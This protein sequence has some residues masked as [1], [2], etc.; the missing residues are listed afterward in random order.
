[1][2]VESSPPPAPAS[3]SG[4]SC[5]LIGCVGLGVATLVACLVFAALLRA[6]GGE[7]L[8]TLINDL[9][10]G[11]APGLPPLTD[12]DTIYADDFTD[13]K[14]G[15]R[16]F[17]GREGSARVGSGRLDLTVVGPEQDV[18][19]T[20]RG[21]YDDFRAEI[22]GGLLAGADDTSYGIIFRYQNDD[23]YYQFDVDG[24][25]SYTLGRI[26]NGDYEAI[27][28][29]TPSEA[30]QK[31]QALNHFEVRC[32]GPSITVSI[33]GRQ[34]D[35]ARDTTFQ[36]GAVGVTAGLDSPSTSQVVFR[37]LRIYRP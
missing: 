12:H 10:F 6:S 36:R 8:R 33:N 14:A 18:W 23:N 20:M 37:A 35:Q 11:G 5:F 27:I 26:V 4:V 7:P 29:L 17:S 19:T 31:G 28:D 15:W 1:M 21:N 30:I 22:D 25:G 32:V 3:R 24:Q 16:E 34:V 13:N 9:R 2:A